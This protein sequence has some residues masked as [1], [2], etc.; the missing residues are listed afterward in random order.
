MLR[1]YQWMNT[2]E[3]GWE[4]STWNT[5]PSYLCQW[6]M[7][8]SILCV[9][10]KRSFNTAWHLNETQIR[11]S[12]EFWQLLMTWRAM[13]DIFFSQQHFHDILYNL[14]NYIILKIVQFDYSKGHLQKK[15]RIFGDIVQIGLQTLPPYPICDN[16][17]WWNLE[18][19][20]TPSL[21]LVNVT[22]WVLKLITRKQRRA[23][24]W[25]KL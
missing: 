6:S 3:R 17:K 16:L 1:W 14:S 12:H 15:M 7:G 13:I 20:V 25:W 18:T 10:S 2:S 8:R 11:V 5:A 24:S 19:F 4:S 22:G 9:C 23:Q 21:L